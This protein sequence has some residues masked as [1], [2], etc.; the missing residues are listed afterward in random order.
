MKFQMLV[1]AAATVTT[2]LP[3]TAAV[4]SFGS[5]A[6]FDTAAGATTTETFESCAGGAG[7]SS[8]L[9]AATPGPCGSIVAGISF[10][11]D[12]GFDLYIAPPGQSAN[13]T[14]ALGVNFPQSGNNNIAFADGAFSFGADF[15]QNFGGGS[16]RGTPVLFT[17]DAFDTLGVLVASLDFS[18]DSDSSTFFGITSTD[19][20][21]SIKVRSGE[22][23][24]AVLDNASFGAGATVPEPASWAMLIAGFGLVGTAM[25]RRVAAAA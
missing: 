3:A 15:N 21:G 14:T 24:Y 17:L 10:S 12:D 1:V 9:S 23:G 18:V 11:P 6:A 16:Q 7:V 19:L 25:R 13:A 22:N 8:T 20:L 2:A 4:T 5:R